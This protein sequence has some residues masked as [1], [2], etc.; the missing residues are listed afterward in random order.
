MSNSGGPIRYEIRDRVG[1]LHF[2]RPE[3]ANTIDLE[4][5]REYLA[6]A[7]ALDD[8]GVGAIVGIQDSCVEVNRRAVR[9]D[10]PWPHGA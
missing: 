4:F 9:S 7:I 8:P 5:A 3:A 1:F 10:Q 2:N 6:A